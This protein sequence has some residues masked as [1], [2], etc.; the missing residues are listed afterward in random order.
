[1]PGFWVEGTITNVIKSQLCELKTKEL[2]VHLGL[3]SADFPLAYPC[4]FTDF[5]ITQFL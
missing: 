3:H 4:L 5:T 1:M 2:H